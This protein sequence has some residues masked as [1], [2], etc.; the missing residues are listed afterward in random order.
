MTRLLALLL[1]ISPAMAH[2]TGPGSWI[3][4]GGFRDPQSGEH[5]CNLHDC[6]AEAVRE[7]S[8]GYA[9]DGGDVVPYSRVIWNSADGR[10]WRC[11]Y[12]GGEKIGKTRCLIGPPPGS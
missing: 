6:R 7:V 9:T 4:S 12:L 2:D 11:R 10:W 8:G 1:L 5:C 3:N